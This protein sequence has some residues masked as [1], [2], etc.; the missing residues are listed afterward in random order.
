MLKFS[1]QNLSN[2][3]NYNSY[4]LHFSDYLPLILC[5]HYIVLT[6]TKAQIMIHMYVVYLILPQVVLELYS[7]G[8]VVEPEM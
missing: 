8:D 4:L 7:L 5:V 6:F 1:L 3:M 2:Y